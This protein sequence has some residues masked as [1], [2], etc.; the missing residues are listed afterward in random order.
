MRDSQDPPASVYVS[1]ASSAELG[2]TQ[3]YKYIKNRNVL[4]VSYKYISAPFGDVIHS[5]NPCAVDFA[6]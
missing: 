2:Y 3:G 5:S 4:E 6:P 1:S